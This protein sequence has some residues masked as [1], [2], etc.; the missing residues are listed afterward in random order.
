MR[1]VYFL[2]LLI[3]VS[4]AIKLSKIPPNIDTTHPLYPHLSA[5]KEFLECLTEDEVRMFVT[6]IY[7]DYDGDD[8]DVLELDEVANMFYE[9]LYVFDDAHIDRINQ[10]MEWR[11][12]GQLTK[13]EAVNY[14]LRL[15]DAEEGSEK[16]EK[17]DEDD[18]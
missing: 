11:Y 7:I 5:L 18:D 2:T 1:V 3:C 8:D 10:Y 13:E 9:H 6:A 17:E 12:N 14:L 16:R 15:Q 4:S